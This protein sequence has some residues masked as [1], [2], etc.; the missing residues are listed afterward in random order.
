MARLS[1]HQGRSSS[2][3]TRRG[4]KFWYAS[5][6]RL[7]G[8]TADRAG[9]RLYLGVELE[10]DGFRSDSYAV[11]CTDYV[12]SVLGEY[13]RCMSDGSLCNGFEIVFDPMTRKAF[14]L[15][16]PLV[17][18]VMTELQARGGHSHD[19]SN[20][21]LHVHVSRAALG[22]TDEAKNLAI[23]KLLEVTERFQPSISAI[24]RRDITTAGWCSPT[25]YGHATTDSSRAVRRKA[26]RIQ[27]NQGFACHDTRRYR[28]WNFQ[29]VPTI[30][31]RAFKG[32][33]K[34]STFFATLA[35]VDG[36]VR[37]CTLHTT[38]EVHNL[39]GL[40]DIITWTVHDHA[41]DQGFV[42]LAT[43][44]GERRS[45]VSR[46]RAAYAAALQDFSSHRKEHNAMAKSL[47][48]VARIVESLPDGIKRDVMD[49]RDVR[50]SNGKSCIRLMLDRL[51]TEDEKS[52]LRRR[53]SVRGFGQGYYNYA[54]EIKHSFIDIA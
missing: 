30:E 6:G 44:W 46:Y 13:A 35:F 10:V 38:P 2:D 50:M 17:E 48:T 5:N 32:T 27:D 11:Q 49:I 29:N 24:A 43:Y 18:A 40:A 53:R 42:D 8:V 47:N 31:C 28:V 15:I 3:T 37:Y 26:T 41:D 7:K 25:G 22:T 23:G 14:E 39:S 9:S 34:A 16:R 4:A 21:G 1:Y 45:M 19:S 33:L 51:L 54:P 12:D 52:E 20:C 36:L